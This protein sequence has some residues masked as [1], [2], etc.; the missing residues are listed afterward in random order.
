MI[1]WVS[2]SDKRKIR[3]DDV[4]SVDDINKKKVLDSRGTL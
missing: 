4:D 2:V 1:F 3:I